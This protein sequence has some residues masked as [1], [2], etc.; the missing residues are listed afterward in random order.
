[1]IYSL[2]FCY[3]KLHHTLHALRLVALT[4]KV[5]NENTV[6]LQVHGNLDETSTKVKW[7]IIRNRDSKARRFFVWSNCYT[8]N[9]AR[10]FI[11]GLNSTTFVHTQ[12][13]QRAK[14]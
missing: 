13:L 9:E 2:C 10:S 5:E 6:N 14:L 7:V 11:C 1:M 3:E 4:E 8:R 12:T